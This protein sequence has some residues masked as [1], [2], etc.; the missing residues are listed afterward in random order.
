MAGNDVIPQPER[1][2]VEKLVER[3]GSSDLA[4]LLE[5]IR[6]LGVELLH[7]LPRLRRLF[8]AVAARRAGRNQRG[9][10]G[11]DVGVEGDKRLLE[12]LRESRGL[13]EVAE[14]SRGRMS[15]FEARVSCREKL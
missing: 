12:L 1:P 13:L 11:L 10:K 8:V 14:R 9:L 7:D 5:A 15:H 3:C 2:T 6:E 4:E